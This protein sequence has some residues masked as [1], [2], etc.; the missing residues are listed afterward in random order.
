VAKKQLDALSYEGA[1]PTVNI[2]MFGMV[3]LVEGMALPNSVADTGVE[4][5]TLSRVPDGHDGNSAATDWV[6]TKTSTPGAA[7]AQ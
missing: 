5:G 2:P 4:D 1:L 3:T 7:N 6:Y